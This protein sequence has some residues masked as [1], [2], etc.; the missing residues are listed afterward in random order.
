MHI[1]APKLRQKK[2]EAKSASIEVVAAMLLSQAKLSVSITYATPA[3]KKWK[4]GGKRHTTN[5][6]HAKLSASKHKS[7]QRPKKR[8]KKV[9]NNGKK[10]TKKKGG[11][12]S[13]KLSVSDNVS[14]STHR[15]SKSPPQK[16]QS[17]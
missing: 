9:K 2:R 8:Q 14:C 3:E 5:R 15:E 1:P 6:S 16:R 4:K 11:K 13:G 7:P 10:G 12:K 17:R